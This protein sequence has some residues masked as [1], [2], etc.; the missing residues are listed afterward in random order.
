MW[1]QT[2][3]LGQALERS[4][5]ESCDPLALRLLQERGPLR[6][7][8]EKPDQLV[9]GGS[10]EEPPDGAH[11][12]LRLARERDLGCG[13]YRSPHSLQC[14]RIAACTAGNRDRS[15]RKASR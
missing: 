8:A 5:D 9:L 3:A 13:Q 6:A 4:G 1:D 12:H 15:R 14:S 11:E 10:A 7:A 2:L